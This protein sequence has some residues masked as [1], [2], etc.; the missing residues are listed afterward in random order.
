MDEVKGLEG[1]LREFL[2]L[3]EL[4]REWPGGGVHSLII[5]LPQAVHN[6]YV[7]NSGFVEDSGAVMAVTGNEV[8]MG[9]NGGQVDVVALPYAIFQLDYCIVDHQGDS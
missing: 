2:V 3:L 8:E 4:E 9:C 1:K 5:S 6:L 7:G